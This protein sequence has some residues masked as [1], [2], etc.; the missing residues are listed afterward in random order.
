MVVLTSALILYI[1]YS[2]FLYFLSKELYILNYQPSMFDKWPFH[3]VAFS[4]GLPITL[5][6]CILALLPLL[7]GYKPKTFG[8]CIAFDGLPI[9]GSYGVGIFIFA[10]KNTSIY[11]KR[12]AFGQCIQQAI[13][14][15]FFISVIAIPKL[16]RYLTTKAMKTIPYTR[17]AMFDNIWY[18]GQAYQL[19][20]YHILC[21]VF[22]KRNR[23]L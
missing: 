22:N 13:F 6:G 12:F 20:S 10:G 17:T 9:N 18:D 4:W 8:Y 23:Q 15:I 19:G 5:F 16:F 1:S 3:S 21:D 14:G 2:V 7:C 11:D